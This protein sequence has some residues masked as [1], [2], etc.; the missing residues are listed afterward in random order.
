MYCT[1]MHKLCDD[2]PAKMERGIIFLDEF[3]KLRS[4]NQALDVR[5]QMAQQELL[6][7]HRRRDCGTS[8]ELVEIGFPR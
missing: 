2:D 7:L 5:G 8:G 1:G 3:D 4:N 6:S